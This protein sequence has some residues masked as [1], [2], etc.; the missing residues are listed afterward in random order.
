M[1]D[2][3]LQYSVISSTRYDE[4]LLDI[5]W[6]TRVNDGTPTRFMLLPWHFSRL[7]AAAEKHGWIPSRERMERDDLVA[8]CENAV[9]AARPQHGDGPFKVSPTPSAFSSSG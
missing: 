4:A 2:A 8:A 7:V 1:A 5:A 3:G 6:N 9:D